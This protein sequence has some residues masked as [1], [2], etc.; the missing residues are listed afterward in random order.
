MFVSFSDS[1]ALKLY[2][3]HQ[4]LQKRAIVTEIGSSF[5]E[6][7]ELFKDCKSSEEKRNIGSD[8]TNSTIGTH[9]Y[10]I[11]YVCVCV[12]GVCMFV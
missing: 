1:E 5:N 9:H 10:Y 7:L 8:M 11:T 2:A 3:H 6:L 4:Y 12:C